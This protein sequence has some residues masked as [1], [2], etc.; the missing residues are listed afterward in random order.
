[1]G[2]KVKI[3]G[4]GIM[5]LKFE[6]TENNHFKWGWGDEWFNEPNPTKR[7]KVQLGN[8]SRP[9]GSFRQECIS[10]AK[11]LASKTTKPIV[12]GLSGGSDSQIVCLALREAGIPFKVVIVKLFTNGELQNGHD[13]KTAFKF[14]EKYKIEHIDYS[15]NTDDFY[16]TKALHYAEKYGFTGV[17]T[18]MQCETMDYLG[19]DYCYIMAGGDIVM[20]S[21][22]PH[23]LA[24]SDIKQM[25]NCPGSELIWWQTPQPIMRHMMEMGYEGTSKFFLYTPEL[26]SAYL[27]DP[28]VQDFLRARH[29]TFEAFMFWNPEPGQWWKFFQMLIKPMMTLREWPEMV[30]ARKWTGFEKLSDSNKYKEYQQLIDV[31]SKGVSMGQAVA[32]PIYDLI[33]YIHTPH[34]HSLVAIDVDNIRKYD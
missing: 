4:K 32:L 33:D 28:V 11:L 13:I 29:V 6:Y 20:Q 27:M 26:I 14:C 3:G 9:V 18:I 34:T 22:L 5:D 19:H 7:F 30:P 21:K 31:A 2:I 16:N 24:K 8:V 10:A 17:E 12:V 1:M 23:V 15:I 25:P